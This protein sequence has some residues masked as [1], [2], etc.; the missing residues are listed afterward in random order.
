[1]SSAYRQLL[2]KLFLNHT[3][4]TIMRQL[5]LLSLLFA[6]NAGAHAATWH[7]SAIDGDD[8][9]SGTSIKTAFKTLQKAES[10]V[11]PGDVV[12]IGDGIYESDPVKNKADGSALLNITHNG[13][14]DAWITWKARP[15]H[16]PELRPRGWAGIQVA[17]SYQIIEGLRIIG[18]NDEIYLKAAIEA[19]KL[20]EKD[21]YFNTNGILIEG[22]R[23]AADNKPHHIIVRHCEVAKVPGG[24]I[25]GMEADYVTIEDN[26][27]YDNA[28]Y[29]EFGGSGIT[30]LNNWAYD[31]APGYHIIVR[32]NQ[33]WNN[34]TLVPWTNIGK[35]SDGNGILLDVTDQ[36]VSAG[37]TNPNADAV[38]ATPNAAVQATPPSHP[39]K[40]KRPLWTGRALIAN[41]LSAFNGGSGIHTFRTAHVDII[42]NTT[43]WNGSVVGY[44]ELFANRS[45]DVVILNNII[46]PRPTGKV[47]SD[48]RNTNVRWDY[49]IYPAAQ[50]VMVGS[51][52][53]VAD[54]QFV[55]VDR[56]LKR[57]DFRLRKGSPARGSGSADVAQADDLTGARRPATGRD[58]G[59]YE[60]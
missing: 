42:N 48:N 49:N 22:R 59:A 39:D 34:K 13:R 51:H 24:G 55:N 1:M 28:W 35:L 44:E 52:D 54:P 18:A 21:A 2:A 4:K 3:E 5:T 29:M 43:Y 45:D 46:V 27:V 19:A 25:A 57:A 15:G 14:P 60:Q 56:D 32:R 38:I 37:A 30:F 58:R 8:S 23:N 9:Q 53:I 12:L 33:V 31:D 36:Q 7:V 47:T 16:K 17:A 26:L 41:N 10:V 6:L 11:Q 50:K 20:K 40:A